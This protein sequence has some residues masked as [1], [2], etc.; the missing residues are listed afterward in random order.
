[1]ALKHRQMS[2]N[3]FHLFQECILS[4]PNSRFNCD[5]KV[6]TNNS[7]VWQS[8]WF[9][10]DSSFELN[11]LFLYMGF[12]AVFPIP[13]PLESN[14]YS[15]SQSYLFFLFHWCNIGAQIECFSDQY[16]KAWHRMKYVVH[17]KKC[18]PQMMQ[19]KFGR[20]SW[21]NN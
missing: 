12:K 13:S 14:F 19:G 18:S 20:I 4:R 15:D 8:L 16:I 2:W 17:M 11:F 1:M 7:I 5:S 21:I 6:K 9:E 3:I 10:T